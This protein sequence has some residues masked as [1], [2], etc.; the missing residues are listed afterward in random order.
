MSATTPT[1]SPPTTETETPSIDYRVPG[2]PGVY[3]C[4]RHKNV[5]TR[6]RCGRCEK[7]ICPKCTKMGPTGARCPDCAS[8]RT[9]HIYQVSPLQFLMAFGVGFGLSLV[10]TAVAEFTGIYLLV[11]FAPVVGTF[12]AKA[13][14]RV[15]KGK[16]GIPL[17]AVTSL[18]IL[19]GGAVPLAYK[20]MEAMALAHSSSPE[21]AGSLYSLYP[22]ASAG[23]FIVL[24]ISG[25]W[26]WLK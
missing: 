10:G 13:V 25:V 7:P 6:L 23:G 24:A 20:V 26:Y 19:A 2:E 1:T 4:A 18:G 5:K 11:F 15:V 9:S 16:R 14:L 22:F 21:Y 17:A 12:I 3:F 8:N